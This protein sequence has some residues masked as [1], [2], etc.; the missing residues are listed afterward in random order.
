MEV[1]ISFPLSKETDPDYKKALKEV[2]ESKK[3]G[4]K[5]VDVERR[6]VGPGQFEGIIVM[7]EPV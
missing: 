6:Q 7:E 3:H 5:V 1:R 4:G 2:E